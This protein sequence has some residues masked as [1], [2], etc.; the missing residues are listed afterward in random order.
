[1]QCCLEVMRAAWPLSSPLPLPLPP[2]PA[3]PSAASSMD[4]WPKTSARTAP[5]MWTMLLRMV[6][7]LRSFEG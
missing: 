3:A 7:V 1:M 5:S 6:Y 4:W 2:P